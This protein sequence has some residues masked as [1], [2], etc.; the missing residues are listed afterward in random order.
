MGPRTL[1]SG[2]GREMCGP[3]QLPGPVPRCLAK[4]G[5]RTLMRLVQSGTSYLSQDDMRQHFGLGRE[6]QADVV[7]VYWPDGTTTKL[8]NVRANQ[9]VQIEQ[10][11]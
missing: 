2:A 6:K 4:I 7:E 9:I 8:E 1:P 3:L 5:K 11:R 10:P